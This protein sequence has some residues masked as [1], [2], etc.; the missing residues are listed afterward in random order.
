MRYVFVVALLATAC[1]K[2]IGDECAISSDCDPNGERFCDRSNGDGYC[3]IQG[4]GAET[5]PDE[6]VCVRFFNGA[7]VNRPCDPTLEF[8]DVRCTFDEICSLAGSCVPR[9]SETR[10]CMRKCDDD[11]DCRDGYE[12]RGRELMIQHGGEPVGP[13]PENGKFCAFARP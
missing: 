13:S 12:C 10:F 8:P 6:A 4:C 9:S 3:T 7:F 5:C 11:G 2:E 1:S